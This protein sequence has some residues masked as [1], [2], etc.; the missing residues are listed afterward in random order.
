[1]VAPLVL[2]APWLIAVAWVVARSWRD[3]KDGPAQPSLAESARRR[4]LVR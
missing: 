2:T 3:L 4:L 1:M